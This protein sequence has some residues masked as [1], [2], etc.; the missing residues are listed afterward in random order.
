MTKSFIAQTTYFLQEGRDN[1]DDCLKIAFQA[2]VQQSI[3]K[4]VIFTAYGEGV[5]RAVENFWVH[6]EYAHIGLVA[7]TFPAGKTFTDS[8]S[9]P[10][11]ATIAG[12]IEALM[13]SH[14]IPLVRA[15]LPFDAVEP[16]AAL[17]T[18]VGR[19][20]N[21]LGETLNMFCGSMSLC[22]QAI[23][24]ACDAGRVESGEHVIALTS[25]TAILARAAVT[26]KMLSQMV[27]REVLCKPAIL[28]IGRNESAAAL[29]EKRERKLQP[30][31][32]TKR[33]GK[34]GPTT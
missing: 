13:E 32:A 18:T 21:L 11:E 16:G 26:R 4:L 15:H 8:N 3:G 34:E 19:G 29:P 17:Q 1:L 14:K 22:V 20:F 2:A 33:L 7:V 24:L 27:I 25:D 10:Y 12:E 6:Q 5:K 31:R 23:A 30:K 28:T 9:K